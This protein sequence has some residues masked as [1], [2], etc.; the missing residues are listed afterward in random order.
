MCIF[1]NLLQQTKKYHFQYAYICEKYV[2]LHEIVSLLKMAIALW[3]NYPLAHMIREQNLIG[4]IR[5]LIF[6][7]NFEICVC[8]TGTK[9]NVQKLAKF[10]LYFY[11]RRILC[12]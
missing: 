12:T 4:C 10:S 3:V 2:I 9:I 8:L 7:V 11:C 5:K 1:I 6:L